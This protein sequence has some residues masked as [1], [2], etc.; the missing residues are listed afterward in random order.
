MTRPAV[1]ALILAALA[2]LCPSEP[3]FRAQNPEGCAE[4]FARLRTA[5][6]HALPMEAEFR[7]VLRARALN[8]TEVEEGTVILAPGGKM[9]WAY[10]RPEGKL[11]VADGKESY[12]Y[13]PGS[14]EVFIQPINQEGPLLFRLLS[15]QVNLEEEMACE[16]VSFHGEEAVLSLKLLKSSA[17]VR[18][19]EVTTEAATGQVRRISYLDPLGNEVSLTLSHIRTPAGLTPDSFAFKVPP[20]VKVIRAE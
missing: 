20:G 16:G 12:L 1:P 6:R 5:Y 11:A 18:R 19:V 3:L 8:Q 9:R 2:V 7:H 15:G 10:T 13:L 14:R 17:D 4:A